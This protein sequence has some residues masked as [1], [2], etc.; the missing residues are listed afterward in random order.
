MAVKQRKLHFILIGSHSKELADYSKL[1]KKAQY[2]VTVLR[3]HQ[4]LLDTITHLAADCIIYEPSTLAA[5]IQL[6]KHLKKIRQLPAFILLI[7]SKYESKCQPFLSQGLSGYLTK[8]IL[9]DTF[10]ADV[11][12]IMFKQMTIQ[13]WGVRGTFPVSGIKSLKYGGNTNC[14]SLSFAK[15]EFII[16]DAGTG[17][18]ELSNHYVKQNKFPINAKIFVSHPHYDHI[19][20]IPLFAPLY[21][22]GNNIEIFGTHHHGMSIEQLI[23]GQ[24]DTIY[25]PITIKAFAANLRFRSLQEET[26]TLGELIVH[27]IVLKN[28][29][30]KSLGYRVDYHD[31][32]FCYI[33]DNELY[34]K[35][36]P[37]YKKADV[38]KLIQFIHKATVVVIDSTY[39]DADYAKRIGWGHSCL[40]QVVD[41]VD[42]AEVKTMCL[43][44]HSPD[45]TDYE[46]DQKLKTV[47]KLLKARKSKT[48]CIAPRE[49]GKLII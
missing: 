17:M 11:C 23:S 43:Y 12:E 20:S 24:M 19:N 4:E 40:S 10:V 49:G 7:P 42:R 26:F 31:K 35:N 36:S 44:H 21:M 22:K 25:F 8:P 13:F 1:L 45:Q 38:D 9:S 37:R 18:K 5:G 15:Q 29:P 34:F 6:L 46:I 16:F 32:S 48:K 3:P 33:T 41:L 30:G 47:K 14:I 27:T 28:H 2:R 39:T